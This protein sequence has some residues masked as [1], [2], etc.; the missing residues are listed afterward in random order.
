M[1]EYRSK[2][3][4]DGKTKRYPINKRQPIGID[5]TLSLEEVQKLRKQG[6]R[7]RNME[8]NRAN[9]S[10]GN[11]Y[12]PAEIIDP[13]TGQPTKNEIIEKPKEPGESKESKKIVTLAKAQHLG[14]LVHVELDADGDARKGGVYLAQI[15]GSDSK[16][17]YKREF[18]P[19]QNYSAGHDKEVSFS[20]DLRAGTIIERGNGG[21]G[22]YSYKD[23]GIVQSN[24][25]VKWEFF[26]PTKMGS[27]DYIKTKK[28]YDNIIKNR[29]KY[30]IN[31]NGMM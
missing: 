9:K 8:T 6:Y 3:G 30:K 2:K 25:N 23:I 27:H 21:S 10:H 15:T 17:G 4:K 19:T 24:G 26:T 13:K 11:L 22:Q 14:K 5:R 20:G 7:A 12:A 28:K 29:E 16:W 18:L 31:S 1:T